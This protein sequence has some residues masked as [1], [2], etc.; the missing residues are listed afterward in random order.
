VVVPLATNLS[1]AFSRIDVMSRD[2]DVIIMS[3]LPVQSYFSLIRDLSQMTLE[4]V[5]SGVSYERRHGQ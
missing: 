1:K 4:T 2:A 3:S 5:S